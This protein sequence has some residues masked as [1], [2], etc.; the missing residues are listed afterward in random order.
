MSLQLMFVMSMAKSDH[1]TVQYMPWEAFLTVVFGTPSEL[2]NIVKNYD[3][4]FGGPNL[5][6][7]VGCA[8]SIHL[9]SKF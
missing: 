6:K 8:L 7:D 1:F 5:S 9:G 3:L 2:D 4:I